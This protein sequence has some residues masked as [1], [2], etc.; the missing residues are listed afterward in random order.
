MQYEYSSILMQV[1]GGSDMNMQNILYK[2]S[3]S[4]MSR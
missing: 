2:Y 4:E 3:G 1:H